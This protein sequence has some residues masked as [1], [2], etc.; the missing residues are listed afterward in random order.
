MGFNCREHSGKSSDRRVG[1]ANPCHRCALVEGMEQRQLLSAAVAPGARAAHRPDANPTATITLTPSTTFQTIQGWLGI[2]NLEGP[3]AFQRTQALDMLVND[4]GLT[5]LRLEAPAGNEVDGVSWEATPAEDLTTFAKTGAPADP[6]YSDFDTSLTDQRVTEVVVPFQQLVDAR[7]ANAFSL[8]TSQSLYNY[9]SSG[10][11]PTWMAGNPG[12]YAENLVSFDEYLKSKYGIVP[13]YMTILN[14][15][16][17]QTHMTPVLNAAIIRAVGPLLQKAGLST[18]VLAGETVTPTDVTPTAPTATNYVSSLTAQDWKYIAGISYHNYGDT[19]AEQAAAYA[20]AQSQGVFASEDESTD[21]DALTMYND[22]V[23]G[24]TSFSMPQY[25]MVGLNSPGVTSTGVLL[26]AGVDG[27][28]IQPGESYFDFRQVMDYVRPGAV[29]IGASSSNGNIETMAFQDNGQVTTVLINELEGSYTP[30]AQTVTVTGLPNGAYGVSASIGASA[31]GASGTPEELGVQTVTNGTLSVTDP[32]NSVLTVYPRAAGVTLPPYIYQSSALAGA[33]TYLLTGGATSIRLQAT[34]DD[35]QLDPLSYTWSLASAPAGATVSLANANAAT[36]TA[37]GLTVAGQYIFNVTASNGTTSSTR[38]VAFSV[39][40]GPQQPYLGAIQ[41]RSPPESMVPTSVGPI[42]HLPTQTST[43]L[44]AQLSADLQGDSLT[45]TW[46]YVSGPAGASPV[47]TSQAASGNPGIYIASNLT[48]PGNYTFQVSA[49]DGVTAPVVD[50]LVVTVD[51]ANPATSLTITNAS[52]SYVSPS[53]G[54]LS[55]ISTDVNGGGQ[56]TSSWWDVVTQPAGSTVNFTDQTSP[57][58]NFTADTAGQYQFQLYSVDQTLAATSPV[59]TV[60]ISA[61]APPTV[62]SVTPED[63][64]GNGI[65][66]GSAAKGQ[67]SM[68]TQIAVVFSE[69]VN[70]ASDAFALGLVNNYGS[71]TNNGSANT[72]L[73]GVLGTPTNPSGD[74]ETWIIPILSNGTNSYALRGTHGG[75]NGAS[76]DNGVYQLDVVAS[77]VTA[78]SGGT[79]MAANFT[80]AAWHRLFGDVDNAGRVFNT[81]YSALLSAFSSTYMSNGATNYNQDLDYDSDGRVFNTDYAAFLADFGSTK[82][83]TEPQS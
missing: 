3:S 63:S 51:A 58:T 21:G 73:T 79:A 2:A 75:I 48:V 11:I 30:V 42:L 65:A 8:Y 36:A 14:E 23:S 10:H 72:S 71:G 38:Q 64:A 47:L 45:E 68:E 17:N 13:N 59:I 34:A 40:S 29:R 76:L 26:N 12:E 53:N 31:N 6:T 50:D 4:L 39:F 44:E 82:I 7:Q 43:Q 74:D 5:G 15:E 49:T 33:A 41:S 57:T 81:E 56:W 19:P 18:K 83:Y 24:S 62:V 1:K 69:P 28:S 70:L 20:E 32:A 22:L 77:D 35:P 67:R 55:A 25:G 37:N 52:G 60:N 80:S 16:D 54:H 78:V 66:A 61:V 9:G 46:L 27:S